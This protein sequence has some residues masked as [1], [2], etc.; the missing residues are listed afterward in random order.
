MGTGGTGATAKGLTFLTNKWS[1]GQDFLSADGGVST[2]GSEVL[3]AGF[4]LAT[5]QEITI[6][7]DQPCDAGQCGFTYPGAVA[8]RKSQMPITD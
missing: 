6:A 1:G 8:R 2:S 7:S 5:D 3:Q 4:E